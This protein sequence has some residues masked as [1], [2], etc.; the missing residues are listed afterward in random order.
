LPSDQIKGV[1]TIIPAAHPVGQM[2]LNWGNPGADDR[3]VT[4]TLFGLPG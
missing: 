2:D 1:S 3:E 4:I